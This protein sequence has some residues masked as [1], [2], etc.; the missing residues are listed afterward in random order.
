MSIQ[1]KNFFSI[2]YN[3]RY[4]YLLWIQLIILLLFRLF[5]LISTTQSRT[6]ITFFI[7]NDIVIGF[8]IIE[9]LIVIL[10]VS[11]IPKKVQ[12]QNFFLAI[13][14][15]YLFLLIIYLEQY[16]FPNSA[17][18][19]YSDD[20]IFVLFQLVILMLLILVYRN[21][22]GLNKDTSILT[23]ILVVAF[24][25]EF[26][27]RLMHTNFDLSP[28]FTILS[29]VVFWVFLWFII[30]RFVWIQ[31]R[32]SSWKAFIPVILGVFFGIGMFMGM[33][34]SL[35]DQ[36]G[37]TVFNTIVDQSFSLHAVNYT[38]F[39]FNPEIAM[40]VID[41]ITAFCFLFELIS[42]LIFHRYY[43]REVVLIMI[44]GITGLAVY[45][46]L[47]IIRFLALYEFISLNKKISYVEK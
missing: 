43:S 27:A 35:G 31:F 17:F 38:L 28:L 3:K 15:L 21:S 39:G 18:Q 42:I 4:Y 25:M 23:I 7:Q 34:K 2:D 5:T 22:F 32:Y 30:V 8:S 19:F 10:F 11:N 36:L 13:L 24:I 44:I 26:F 1:V 47:G 12:N 6:N 41:L 20:L 29:V 46:L 45:P 33:M 40:I 9:I 37:R 16:I 14:V